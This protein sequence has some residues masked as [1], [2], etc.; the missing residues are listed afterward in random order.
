MKD[1]EFEALLAG[2]K[3]PRVKASNTKK[4]ETANL[5][6]TI[7]LANTEA[8]KATAQTLEL[9]S[10]PDP[11]TLA[12]P[13]PPSSNQIHVPVARYG[14]GGEPYATIVLSTDAK[15]FHK[16]V[17]AILAKE[18]PPVFRGSLELYAKI[19]A[20][21]PNNRSDVHNLDKILFDSIEENPKKG[22]LGLV[23]NDKMIKH[24]QIDFIQVVKGGAVEVEMGIWSG[25]WS[26]K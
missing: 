14:R 26:K 19:K 25:S 24:T 5:K 4:Y 12:L 1:A 16:A 9:T 6:R 13:Y 10:P 8:Y 11:V 20:Y 15:N 23:E 22:K 21:P 7:A 2:M 17:Q 18:K 3:S